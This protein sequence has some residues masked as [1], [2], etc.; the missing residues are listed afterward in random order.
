[1]PKR[2]LIASLVLV[3]VF[4]SCGQSEEEQRAQA[5]YERELRE[6]RV[7]TKEHKTCE[8]SMAPFRSTLKDLD[9]RLDIGLNYLDYSQQVSNAAALHNQIDFD[10]SIDCLTKVG[11]P[12]EKA[13][14]HHSN[15]YDTWQECAEEL[16]CD[17][18]E[19]ET[20]LRD[21]W[22]KASRQLDKA[23][24]A[25]NKLDPGEKPKKPEE[26]EDE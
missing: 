18:D 22:M 9:G 23:D 21:D 1:M 20:D 26:L 2:G 19:M 17:P 12:L 24:R 6:W 15:A 8:Q 10:A 4:A 5:R 13:L 7:D 16:G 11:L 14:R 25:F 3:A